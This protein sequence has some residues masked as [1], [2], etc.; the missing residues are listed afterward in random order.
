MLDCGIQAAIQQ[1][2][3]RTGMTIVLLA[4]LSLMAL[5]GIMQKLGDKFHATDRGL[6]ESA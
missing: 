1:L 3:V 5:P 4:G 6:H 2:L